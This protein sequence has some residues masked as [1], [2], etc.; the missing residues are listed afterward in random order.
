MRL[1][2]SSIS[3]LFTA[4]IGVLAYVPHK[5]ASDIHR[6]SQRQSASAVYDY[7][8]I[9][10]GTAGLVIA[11]RLSENASISVAVIEAGGFYEQDNPV[12][13]TTPGLD[14]SGCGADPADTN[15]IDWNF[16]TAPQSGVNNRQV[17]YARGK[18]LGGRSV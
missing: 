9:G 12:L 3:I 4:I 6:L 15:A 11:S 8:I 2:N 17:H 13:S 14:S 18:C 5:R 10:G 1:H 7:V 16:V